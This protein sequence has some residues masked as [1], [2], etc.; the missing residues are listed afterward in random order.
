MNENY[1]RIQQII[2]VL[3]LSEQASGNMP[4]MPIS[5]PVI[6]REDRIALIKKL[7]ELLTI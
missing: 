5:S 7:I 3:R 6:T 1:Q 2:E 4:G